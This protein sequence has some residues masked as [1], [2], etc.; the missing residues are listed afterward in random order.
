MNYLSERASKLTPYVAGIQPQEGG[1]VKLNTNENPYPPSQK[2]YE[3]LAE[4]DI[5][6]LRLYPDGD[7]G[8]LR[9]ALAESLGLEPGNIF[10][11]NG[12]DEVLALAFQAFFAGK[13]VLMPDISYGFY[14]V[15]AEM[16]G[17]MAK[18]V[19]VGEDFSIKAA[20]YANANGVVLANPN[21]PT[22]LALDLDE[23][24][25]V[26]KANPDG[27][28]L[29]D[30]AY[31]DFAGVPSAVELIAKYE[32]LLVVRTFSKS[33]SLA[34][35]RVGYAAGN[36]GLIEG[37]MRV[38]NA[39]NSYPLDMLSQRA[40]AAAIRDTSYWEETRQKIMATR[41]KTAA[42]LR[43]LGYG[44]GN[45]QANFLF[46]GVKPGQ[47]GK[48]VYEYLLQHKI[49]VRWWDKPRI[50]NHLRITVGLENEME[51]LINCVRQ[52]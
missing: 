14:P 32:N 26:V 40:A 4:A 41:E 42:K 11:G 36:A 45:S 10:C 52:L 27:V 35:A 37:L 39:F 33:H 30:E 22:G 8:L 13:A 50:G 23:I 18:P 12:S 25:R 34:G 20:D 44:V 48:D 38:K 28:V 31:I 9:E 49:L 21:A 51:A 16:Y 43:E 3:A 19:P 46:A 24:E 17:L 6:R 2:V 1:W 5:T 7:S 15:W 29:V 47:T